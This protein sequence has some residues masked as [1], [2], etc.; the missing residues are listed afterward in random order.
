MATDN[1]SNIIMNSKEQWSG[2]YKSLR[3]ILRNG[4]S[5]FTGMDAFNEINTLLILVFLEDKFDNFKVENIE[6]CKFKNIYDLFYRQVENKIKNE[7][8]KEPI[9]GQYLKGVKI[10]LFNYLFDKRRNYEV[11]KKTG[12]TIS[13]KVR[14]A[15][16][17]DIYLKHHASVFVQILKN[18]KLNRLFIRTKIKD[19][20]NVAD[21]ST[22]TSFIEDHADD[23][24]ILVKKIAETFYIKNEDGTLESILHNSNLD[25]DALGNAYEKFMTDDTMNSKNTGEFFTRRDL[26]RYIM[27]QQN[28]TEEDIVYDSS[29]GTGGFLLEAIHIVKNKLLEE[30][31]SNK[32]TSEQF[33]EKFEYFLENNV[34]GNEIKPNLYK[35]LML[36]VLMH[37]PKGL[38]LKN[39]LCI[40]SLLITDDD[41]GNKTKAL[42][43]STICVGNPPYGVS[44]EKTPANVKI[45][46]IG[47]EEYYHDP[48]ESNKDCDNYFK[49][50]M[51]GKSVIKSS[52]GQFIMHLIRCLKN[53]GKA[54]FIIDRGILINGTDSKNSWQKR[55]R[56]FIIEHNNLRKVVLLPTGIFEHT[57]F[58]TCV[59]FIDKGGKTKETIF[60]E[61]Y[62][63]EEDKG[64]GTKPFY[65]GNSWK[66]SFDKIKAKDF[67][68]D[69]KDYN[70]PLKEYSK[71][72]NDVE[73]VQFIETS[74]K[75]QFEMKKIGEVCTIN[76]GKRIVKAHN[77]T[78]QTDEYPYPVYGGGDIS[79]YTNNFNRPIQGETDTLVMSR[80]GVS[81]N[82]IRFVKDKF[83]LLDSGMSIHTN[84][85]K[86][87][88]VYL[89]KIYQNKIFDVADGP[90]QKNMK[91]EKM[92]DIDI[93]IPSIENQQ[94]IVT[95]LDEFFGE[96][97]T[98]K[99]DLDIIMK[100]SDG[101][102]LLNFIFN[103]EW[104]KFHEAIK[105]VQN[106][107]NQKY[108]HIDDVFE[109]IVNRTYE[110]FNPITKS[111]TKT[112]IDEFVV[113]TF[114]KKSFN[115]ISKDIQ[116][117]NK[118]IKEV[119]TINYGKRIVKAHNSTKQTDEYP[120]PVYG[121]GDISFYTNNF[122]RPI[123]GET[124]TLVMSRFGVSNNCIRFVKDKFFLLDSGMSIHTNLNKYYIVYLLKI[125]QNKIFDVADGPGQK[126]MKIEKMLDIEIPIPS[127][128]N[129]QKIVE[130]L[131]NEMEYYKIFF[132]K[133][134]PMFLN[135]NNSYDYDDLN[136]YENEIHE[137]NINNIEDDE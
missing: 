47:G 96:N 83:F 2:F 51:S 60:E 29:V 115:M 74:T 108:I 57:D 40:D 48:C 64:V 27:T 38:S 97:A 106:A 90:G 61:L 49:P 132:Q 32:I 110:K 37:D 130:Y 120:Y 112:N 43:F 80:F 92:L 135:N 4:S 104:N 77:S 118:K 20:D 3:D 42:N 127:I 66:V 125:Y 131:D 98:N 63:K 78:K 24:Y 109:D 128:E 95:K 137:S 113:S 26:I 88:I 114:L 76:Y 44:L 6:M 59:L 86:Y 126:N 119:C 53:N 67:S 14:K 12:D 103:E 8:M 117:E 18:N 87:Y 101:N 54:G 9:L 15:D 22:I 35:S 50:M 102:K 94:K 75:I 30:L 34:H 55:L 65:I 122:N 91:I 62:F 25:F 41:I 21:I 7:N 129:Q 31:K 72:G 19:N 10:E 1:N 33:Q 100:K 134:T 85:N 89:L 28:I 52:S 23:I 36:N 111:K 99:F 39:L 82:C 79:F 45:E 93:H 68:L 73:E 121:G 123:Q 136:D 17:N 58:A 133:I 16:E 70:L 71:K 124:D 5:K 116:F 13:F 105:K 81:N 107:H 69:P 11:S 84:L 46:I 56:K